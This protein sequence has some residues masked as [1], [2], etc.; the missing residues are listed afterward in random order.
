MRV[1]YKC[2]ELFLAKYEA[3]SAI[4]WCFL[5]KKNCLEGYGG[6]WVYGVTVANITGYEIFVSTTIVEYT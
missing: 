4:N 3:H 6:T 2:G 1:V 5:C